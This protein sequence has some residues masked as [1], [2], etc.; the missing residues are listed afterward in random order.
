MHRL[1]AKAVLSRKGSSRFGRVEVGV[2]TDP[3]RVET[4]DDEDQKLE[5]PVYYLV[6]KGASCWARSPSR[7]QANWTANDSKVGSSVRRAM[8][9]SVTKLQS[10]CDN[11][12]LNVLRN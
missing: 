6:G 12:G 4:N 1:G 3:Q 5:A 8:S 9:E 7:V 11:V 10:E 2:H